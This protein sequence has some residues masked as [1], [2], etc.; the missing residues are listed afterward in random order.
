MSSHFI[1]NIYIRVLGSSR[2]ANV[3]AIAMA[4]SP[5]SFVPTCFLVIRR[6]NGTVEIDCRPGPKTVLTE[7]EEG[8]LADYLVQMSD[9]GY[10]LTREG[11]M[12]LA[13]SVVEKSRRS[14]PFHNGSAGRAWFDGFM[15][16]R[17]NLTIR[18]PQ[19]LSYC[20]AVSANKDTVMDFFGEIRCPLWKTQSCFKA[21]ANIQLR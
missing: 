14:H 20:R 6:V 17:P 3:V 9:M 12:G 19:P 15:R 4:K 1:L 7:E 18:S 11:V 13:F 5:Q 16:R 8:Q 10:G 2:F 21:N